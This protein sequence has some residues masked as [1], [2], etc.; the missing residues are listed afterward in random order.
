MGCSVQP[1]PELLLSNVLDLDAG[2]RLNGRHRLG[3]SL[4]IAAAE[5]RI[6]RRDRAIERPKHRLLQPAP[7]HHGAGLG[8]ALQ[9]QIE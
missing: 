4:R 9:G 3:E 1:G 2:D 7:P 5:R 8:V 6:I